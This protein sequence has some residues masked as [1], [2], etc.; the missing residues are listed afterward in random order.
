MNKF[1]RKTEEDSTQYEF[2][3]PGC[4]HHHFIHEELWNIDLITNTLSPSVLVR[5]VSDSSTWDIDKN[6][7]FIFE[8]T[9]NPAVRKAKGSKPTVCHTFVRKGQ[10]QY[11]NDCTHDLKGKTI[12][13]VELK[14]NI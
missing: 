9:D 5:G 2:Y 4:G 7:D 6:G 1:I 8:A 3:C 13:M 14:E 11:L 10:I 12:P